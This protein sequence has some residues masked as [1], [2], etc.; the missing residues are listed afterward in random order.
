MD[1]EYFSKRHNKLDAD[2]VEIEAKQEKFAKEFKEHLAWYLKD[3]KN[4]EEEEKL[5][6]EFKKKAEELGG[7]TSGIHKLRGA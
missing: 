1:D 4:E 2:K 6:Q 3:A 7:G 5:M